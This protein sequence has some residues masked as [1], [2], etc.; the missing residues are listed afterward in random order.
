MTSLSDTFWGSAALSP[1]RLPRSRRRQNLMQ[2]SK[3][4]GGANQAQP[5]ASKQTVWWSESSTA[6][7]KKTARRRGLCPIRAKDRLAVNDAVNGVK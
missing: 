4:C 7:C 2:A 6:W 5:D 3:R 1:N